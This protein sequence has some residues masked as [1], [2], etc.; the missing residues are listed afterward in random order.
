MPTFITDDGAQI[1]YEIEG[2]GEPILLFVHGW[3]SNLRHWDPQAQYFATKHRVLRV[4]RRGYGRSPAPANYSFSAEREANDL[5]QLAASVG[6]KDAVVVG[7]AG[8][9]PTA[10][11]LA[12][13]HPALVRAVGS[14]EGAALP[15][16]PA[17]RAM[18][19]AM[20]KQLAGP[21]YNDAIQAIYPGFF[22]P[23]T[24]AQRVASYS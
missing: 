10:I 3:C 14:E 22:H 24:D 9:T 7:H 2:T 11:T 1:E 6:V 4:D 17:S 13:Y 21:Q 15:P 12:A 20:V 23:N 19:D 18:L 16:D 5:A 8:G